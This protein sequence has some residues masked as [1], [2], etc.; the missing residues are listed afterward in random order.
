MP[1]ITA[2]FTQPAASDEPD[3]KPTASIAAAAMSIDFIAISFWITHWPGTAVKF[4]KVGAG[5]ARYL[6]Q[7]VLMMRVAAVWERPHA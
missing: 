6:A 2:P 7:F 1:P 4:A 3:D 5:I